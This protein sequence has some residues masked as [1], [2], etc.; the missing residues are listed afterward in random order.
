MTFVIKDNFDQNSYSMI[1]Y[2]FDTEGY[3]YVLNRNT[4]FTKGILVTQEYE[5]LKFILQNYV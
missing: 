5:K 4:I 1:D 2:L 3:D